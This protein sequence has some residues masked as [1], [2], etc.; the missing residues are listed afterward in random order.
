MKTGTRTTEFYAVLLFGAAALL[1][2]LDIKDG[3]VNYALNADMMSD[4]KY[5]VITYIGGRT[6]IKAV[7]VARKPAADD[8]AETVLAKL[9]EPAK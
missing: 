7:G 2:G 9:K 8:V 3:L 1:S 6:A 4:L 5:A